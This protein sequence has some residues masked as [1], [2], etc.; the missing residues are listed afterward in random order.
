[1][2]IEAQMRLARRFNTGPR[3]PLERFTMEW[4]AEE[5]M[6]RELRNRAAIRRAGAWLVRA[7]ENLQ[8]WADRGRVPG[9]HGA[10]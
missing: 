3:S 9:P 10:S 7:G 5:A 6:R 2:Y 4:Y 8:R 1:M